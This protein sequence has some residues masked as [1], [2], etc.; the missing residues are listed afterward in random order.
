MALTE[1]QHTGEFLLSEAP[2]TISRDAATVTV[3]ANTT[4]EAGHVLGKVSASGKYT[5]YDDANSD[6]TEDAAG[7]LYG[8]LVNDT[9]ASVDMDGVVINTTAEVR[10]DDLQWKSGADEDKGIADLA[11]LNIKARD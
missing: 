4:L 2:G 7:V 3:P 5:E 8:T 1:G 6:G 9:N 10:K 11:A